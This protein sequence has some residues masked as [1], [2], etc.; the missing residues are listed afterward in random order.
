[1]TKGKK[2]LA[3]AAS[4]AIMTACAAPAFAGSDGWTHCGLPTGRNTSTLAI[5][6]VTGHYVPKVGTVSWSAHVHVTE[7]TGTHSIYFDVH[8]LSGEERVAD[9]YTQW[10]TGKCDIPY[11]Y[12]CVHNLKLHL[13]GGNNE[14]SWN[15]ASTSGTCD[16]G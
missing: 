3:V 11:R 13:K 1:M 7:L 6:P 8:Q 9:T 4:F 10:G 15:T 2:I 16:F 14:P 12:P 5:A